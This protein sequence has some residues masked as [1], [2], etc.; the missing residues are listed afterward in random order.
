MPTGEIPSMCNAA[1][2]KVA[3]NPAPPPP[4]RCW[5]SRELLNVGTDQELPPESG[6]EHR[7]SRGAELEN[8]ILQILTCIHTYIRDYMCVYC[9]YVCMYVVPPGQNVPVLYLHGRLLIGIGI[10]IPEEL[11]SGPE[12]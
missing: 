3:W 9:M 7:G 1:S 8:V 10:G 4:H 6:A 12:D 11:A 5:E 2:P